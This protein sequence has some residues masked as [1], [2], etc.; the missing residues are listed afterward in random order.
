MRTPKEPIR[1]RKRV[2]KTG[3][4][5]LYLDI[6]IYGKRSYEYLN[7]YLI[8]ERTRA[9]KDKNRQTLQLAEAVRAKRIVELQNNAHGFTAGD[10]SGANFIE[11]YDAL[12]AIKKKKSIST[13][14]LWISARLWWVKKFG[15]KLTFR[16]INAERLRQFK[17]YLENEAISKNSTAIKCSTAASYFQTIRASIRHAYRAGVISADPT[18]SIKNIRYED[19][20]RCYLTIDEVRRMAA[21]PCRYEKLRRAFLFS[22]LTGLRRSDILKLTWGEVRKE[23]EF[24]RIVFK[25]KKTGGLEYIDINPQAVPLMGE[26]KSDNECVFEK[27]TTQTTSHE[28]PRWT[29]AAGINKHVTFHTARHSFAVI[30]LELDV[31]IYTVQKLLG[32]RNIATTQ[33]YAKVVDKKKQEAAMKIPSIFGAET[34]GTTPKSGATLKKY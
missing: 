4:T 14:R 18:G 30:L 15:T 24:T 29:A 13:L 8:P 2:L 10:K 23:G 12:M 5:S 27:F 26:R 6:Y 9:D 33:I 19:S 1:L 22:C 28:L 21:T 31:D 32:H 25:Q 20:E 34:P 16:D 7:L 3:N 11:Y 17:E